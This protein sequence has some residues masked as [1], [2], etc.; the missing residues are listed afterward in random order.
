MVAF[1]T[2]ED[3]QYPCGTE[4][5]RNYFQDIHTI[6]KQLYQEGKITKVNMNLAEA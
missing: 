3:G 2:M 4:G 6:W 1:Y 5:G